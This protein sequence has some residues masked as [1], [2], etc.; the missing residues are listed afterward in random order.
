MRPKG[1]KILDMVCAKCERKMGTTSTGSASTTKV[2]KASTVIGSTSK[3][4][5]KLNENKLLSKGKTQFTAYQNNCKLCKVRVHQKDAQYCQKCS[6]K[7]GICALCG[8]Q[9]LDVSKY[10]QSVI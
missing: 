2:G 1:L 4:G 9:I 7:K 8:V 6:Y 3:T 10:K 5:K